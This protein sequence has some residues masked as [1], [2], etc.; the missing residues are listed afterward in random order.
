MK[1]ID[2]HKGGLC[3]EKGIRKR[4][5]KKLYLGFL[6]HENEI[7]TILHAPK[8]KEIIQVIMTRISP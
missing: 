5:P 4:L 6:P 8:S 2:S 3:R 7:I 1:R